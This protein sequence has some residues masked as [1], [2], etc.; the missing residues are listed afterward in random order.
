MGS[1]I[2]VIRHDARLPHILTYAMM[3]KSKNVDKILIIIPDI[4]YDTVNDYLLNYDEIREKVVVIP[5]KFRD[6]F[7]YTKGTPR[8]FMFGHPQVK[9]I[10]KVIKSLIEEGIPKDSIVF[11]TTEPFMFT[12]HLVTRRFIDRGIGRLTISSFETLSTSMKSKLYRL[13]SFGIIEK[14]HITIAHT[15][16][17]LNLLRTLG[18]QEDKIRMIY[19]GIDTKSFKPR[20]DGY[21]N[22]IKLLFVGRFTK[23]KGILDLISAWR[24][25][26][27][28]VDCDLFLIGGYKSKLSKF[29]ISSLLTGK[30]PVSI[31]SFPNLHTF[32]HCSYDLLPKIYR[33]ADIF[34][35]LSKPIS[36]L[37]TMKWE[38]QFGFSVVEAM[39]SGCALV[40]SDSG[41]LPEVVPSPPNI[42][43]SHKTPIRL[44]ARKIGYMIEDKKSL[45]LAKIY[46][47]NFSIKHFDA[48]K[49]GLKIAKALLS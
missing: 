1:V 28:G 47:R 35:G 2:V 9:L 36:F 32:G 15:N 31:P 4:Y 22:T 37:K 27:E 18:M 40:V 49:Q 21:G 39:A 12:T 8:P 46:N 30:G 7:G 33:R 3:A 13:L 16:M 23:E 41:A 48:R 42:I 19:P 10:D 5:V 38:E 44:L 34:I 43:V 6:V 11:N 17:A 29:I 25:I 26:K 24:I 45:S 20:N 14:P